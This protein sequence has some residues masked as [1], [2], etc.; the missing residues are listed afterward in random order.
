MEILTKNKFIFVL[1]SG[2]AN[3]MEHI[4][5]QL[6]FSSMSLPVSFPQWKCSSLSTKTVLRTIT[7]S[8]RLSYRDSERWWVSEKSLCFISNID[9]QYLKPCV[10]W[11]GCNLVST[12][13]VWESFLKSSRYDSSD[14]RTHCVYTAILYDLYF[15]IVSNS[16]SLWVMFQ[17]K[18]G[19]FTSSF[20]PSL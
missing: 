19:H 16:N 3:H 17:W 2:S 20:S 4:S 8:H 9:S 18:I 13:Q 5:V 11:M 6:Y 1:E 15:C 10:R 14:Q 7:S 12:C